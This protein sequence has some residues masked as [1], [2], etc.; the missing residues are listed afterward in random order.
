MMATQY[1]GVPGGNDGNAGGN[2]LSEGEAVSVAASASLIAEMQAVLTHIPES[3]SLY[4]NELEKLLTAS[5]KSQ[6]SEQRLI[7]R[8]KEILSEIQSSHEAMLRD[9]EEENEA[10]LQKKKTRLELEA[11]QQQI[12]SSN[13][14]EADKQQ[15]LN[16]LRSQLALLQEELS[17]LAMPGT[18]AG[19]E[20]ILNEEQELRIASMKK[21]RAEYARDVEAKSTTLQDLRLE[22]SNL[23]VLVME[24]EAKNSKLEEEQARVAALIQDKQQLS[25]KEIRR[26]NALEKDLKTQKTVLEQ[27]LADVEAK[28]T[29]RKDNEE[30]LRTKELLLRESKQKMERYLKQYDAL[31]RTTHQLTAEMQA[32]WQKNVELH[33]LNLQVEQE[34]QIKDGQVQQAIRDAIKLEKL[35]IITREQLVDTDAKRVQCEN[36]QEKVK[37][38]L[39]EL[40]NG[41]IE[42]EMK[43]SDLLK[44]KLD[45]ML[46]EREVLNKMLVKANDRSQTT[47]DLL[48]IKENT[49]KNLQNEINGL[50]AQVKKQ[51]TQVQQ[52]VSEREKYEKE[53]AQA[54]QKFMTSL[55]EAK[56]QDL[57]VVSLQQKIVESE[58]RLKQQQNLY[59]AV[60][61]DRNLYSKQLIESQEEISEMK[62]KFKIMNHQIEQL[63]EEITAKDHALVKEHFD[64][65]KVDKE[66]EILKNELLRIKKQIQSSEQIILNQELEITKLSK[67]IQEADEEKQRQQKEYGSVVHDRDTLRQQLIQR[68]EELRVLYEKIK[69]QQSTLS[70]GHRQFQD[71][72]NEIQ[73]L[74]KRIHGLAFEKDASGDQLQHEGALKRELLK[75]EKELLEEKTKIRALSEELDHPLNVHRWRKLEGSDPKR[76]EMIRKL[77]ALQRKLTKKYEETTVK[78]LLILE[79][80]KLYVELKTILARQPGAEVAEQ[81]AVYKDTLKGKQQQLKQM[82]DELA[83]YKMQVKEYRRE[84]ELLE[85]EKQRIQQEWIDLQLKSMIPMGNSNQISQMSAYYADSS[86]SGGKNAAPTPEDA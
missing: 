11:I 83:L 31:F 60:R 26:K 57:Q 34:L 39:N 14:M 85:K 19:A 25:E 52:L 27:L 59:E 28:E 8:T 64:H 62:R 82:E 50:K 48:K 68:N 80:E 12:A 1:D 32:Q 46:R 13:Q 6:E 72:Q 84:Q 4:S 41:S 56:L 49:L 9:Q 63:K 70:K 33:K 86:A 44:K 15:K 29:Q 66:K 45:E 74:Q 36:E 16:D 38:E 47:Y 18:S 55:E 30:N 3:I 76:F 53:A 75:L 5:V 24:E 69:I 73:E 42:V 67:I 51:R 2:G 61:T 23:Y 17:K 10:M 78:D 79:K 81:L 71:K 58:S 20:I 40:V 77:Q 37:L 54:T 7:H 22:T 65:H 21:Q 43:Q 35:I